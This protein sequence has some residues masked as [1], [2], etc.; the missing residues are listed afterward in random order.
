MFK[1]HV[2]DWT[3]LRQLPG[4]LLEFDLHRSTGEP[5]DIPYEDRMKAVHDDTLEALQVAQ[6]AGVD[7]LLITHGYSTSRGNNTTSQSIV[8]KLMRSKQS[9]PYVVKTES[10]QAGTVFAACIRK[11]TCIDPPGLIDLGFG[12]SKCNGLLFRRQGDWD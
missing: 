6:A 10:I 3:A 7:W 2:G 9:T 1:K 8:R 5:C 12:F 4:K 11:V